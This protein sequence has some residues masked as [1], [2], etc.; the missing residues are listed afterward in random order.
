MNIEKENDSDAIEL[1]SLGKR[2][3]A[4]I[5]DFLIMLPFLSIMIGALIYSQKI[6]FIYYFAATIIYSFIFI[7]YRIFFA[8]KYGGTLGKLA[9]KI[10]IIDS[11][12]NNLNIRNS[13]LREIPHIFIYIFFAINVYLML[14]FY[15]QSIESLTDYDFSKYFKELENQEFFPNFSTY[16]YILSI[17]FILFNK[18]KKTPHDLIANSIVV[19]SNKNQL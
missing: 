19:N 12:N 14:N 13:V 11:N 10:K 17:L 7:G 5:V 2:I 6:G 16:Y 18:S 15:N 9:V 1:A 3:K 8:F 4:H